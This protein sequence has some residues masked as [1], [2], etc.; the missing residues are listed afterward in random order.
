MPRE[1]IESSPVNARRVY[2]KVDFDVFLTLIIVTIKAG[3]K[4]RKLQK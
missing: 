4:L 3:T 2:A 1:F